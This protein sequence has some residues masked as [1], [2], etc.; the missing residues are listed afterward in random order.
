MPQDA[1][2]TPTLLG[3]PKFNT[4]VDAPS[5]KGGNA[6]MD[7]IDVLIAALPQKPVGIVTGETIVYNGTT[8]D[9]SSVTK[10]GVG[11]LAITGTPNGL[12]FLR[13]DASWQAVSIPTV[14]Y[15]TTL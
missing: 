13:D 5:G 7:A 10:L 6:Q 8:W 14:T 2:G 9:R 15:Q 3:I 12:K 1:T 11:S 4:A